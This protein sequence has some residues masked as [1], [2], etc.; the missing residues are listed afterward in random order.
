MALTG[1]VAKWRRRW[2]CNSRCNSPQ[3]FEATSAQGQAALI[4]PGW[5][6]YQHNTIQHTKRTISNAIRFAQTRLVPML[7]DCSVTITAS[8]QLCVT[9]TAATAVFS[10]GTVE[11]HSQHPPSVPLCGFSQYCTHNKTLCT[12]DAVQRW[13]IFDWCW[14]V[15]GWVVG[16]GKTWRAKS[17]TS[18]K[19]LL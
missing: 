6:E 15:F 17:G 3:V 1:F 2:D 14:T 9:D 7:C 18:T 19:T 16:E 4:S 11:T 13:T 5:F 8:T 12:D 10:R